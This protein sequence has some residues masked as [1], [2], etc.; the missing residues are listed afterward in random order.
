MNTEAFHK[1]VAPGLAASEEFLIIRKSSTNFAMKLWELDLIEKS[2]SLNDVG[3]AAKS[4][5]EVLESRS[6]MFSL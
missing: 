1:N 4:V 2:S 3:E 5:V 6:K